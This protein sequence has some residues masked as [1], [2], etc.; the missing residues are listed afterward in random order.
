[1]SNTTP[2]FG[3]IEAGGTKVIVAIVDGACVIRDSIR[4]PTEGPEETIGV[5]LDWMEQ[6][7]HRHGGLSAVGIA[8]FGPADLD[9]ASPT[10][11]YIATTSKPGWS[12]ADFAGPFK[13][14]FGVPIGFDT[15]VNG[16]ALA[17]HRWGQGR[18]L[19]NSVYITIGTG[20]GGGAIVNGRL[21]HGTSHPEIGHMYPR[22]HPDDADFA[23]VCPFHGDCFEGVASGPAIL[24]RWGKTLS[25]LPPDHPAQDMQAYY[26]AQLTIMMQATLAPEKI[27]IGGGV[28]ATP[29]LI[30]RIA[31]HFDKLGAGFFRCVRGV[32]LLCLPGLGNQAGILGALALAKDALADLPST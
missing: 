4:I 15:D 20:I 19:A 11:G 26:M 31:V 7:A 27:I 6:A 28:S 29:G 16:A 32:D 18:G 22:K 24:A 21:V 5:A 2:L 13:R 23:G 3:C 14:A 10:W 25:A 17:E 1:M 8:S 12:N 9:V 30:P